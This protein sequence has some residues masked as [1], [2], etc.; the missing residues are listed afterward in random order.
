MVSSVFHSFFTSIF[1]SLSFFSPPP[2]SLPPLGLEFEDRIR[3]NEAGNSKFN[4][5]KPSDPYHAYYRHKIK[6]VQEGVAQEA[7]ATEQAP[8]REGG[9]FSRV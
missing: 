3:I 6:E 9:I 5:L 7:A 1:P 2:F 4:F 8:V